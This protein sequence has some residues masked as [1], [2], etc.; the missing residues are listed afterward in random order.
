MLSEAS[1]KQKLA[2]ELPDTSRKLR[3][4]AERPLRNILLSL[5]KGA[6]ALYREDFLC[7]IWKFYMAVWALNV[8]LTGPLVVTAGSALENYP[9]WTF[10]GLRR[11]S[12]THFSEDFSKLLCDNKF[13]DKKS[14]A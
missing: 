11:T 7:K 12:G 9:W 8:K 3:R 6:R 10:R 14:W 1:E 13:I 5:L 4:R 2:R